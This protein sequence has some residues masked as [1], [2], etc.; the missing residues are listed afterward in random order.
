VKEDNKAV[1]PSDHQLLEHIVYIR[2]TDG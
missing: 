1:A 2:P